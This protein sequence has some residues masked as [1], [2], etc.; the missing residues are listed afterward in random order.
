[1]CPWYRVLGGGPDP[2]GEGHFGIGRCPVLSYLLFTYRPDQDQ[3]VGQVGPGE[4]LWKR[5][6]KHVN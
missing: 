1:L 4:R 2:Q 6:V 5:T 3:E